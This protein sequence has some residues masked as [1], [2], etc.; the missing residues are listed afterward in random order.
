M[1]RGQISREGESFLFRKKFAGS[2]SNFFRIIDLFTN[3]R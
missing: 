2:D 1:D 3:S